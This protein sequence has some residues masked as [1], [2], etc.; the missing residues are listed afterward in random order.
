MNT[1]H[2]KAIVLTN[3][4]GSVSAAARALGKHQSQVS[5]WISDLEI[6]LGVTLFERTGN[7]LGLSCEGEVIL[8][9]IIHTV[10]QAEKLA[11]C[12]QAMSAEEPV[13][14]R[15]GVDNYIPQLALQPALASMLQDSALNLEVSAYDADSLMDMLQAQTLD[16]ALLSES[17][18]LHHCDLGY[19]RLGCYDE[20]LVCAAGHPLAQTDCVTT[21]DLNH[22]RELIWTRENVTENIAGANK[23]SYSA[24]Y[25]IFSELAVLVALLRNCAGFAVLPETMITEALTDGS[26]VVLTTDFE[27]QRIPRRVELLWQP[28]LQMSEKGR[29]L[30]AALQLQHGFSG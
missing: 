21:A 7:S 29:R 4:L 16:I 25:G 27:Q 22:F 24:A 8:P 18:V 23:V 30:I 15:L 10:S 28:A 6:D 14:L 17:D 19:C 26:L 12:A 1:L 2:L 3:E 11:T 13:T 20:V 9:M 5:Q